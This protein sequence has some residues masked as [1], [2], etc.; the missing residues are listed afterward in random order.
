MQSFLAEK[1]CICRLDHWK[2]TYV[3]DVFEAIRE[4]LDTHCVVAKVK[5]FENAPQHVSLMLLLPAKPFTATFT[6]VN[7]L[8]AFEN[9]IF[10]LIICRPE[11]VQPRLV[12]K[13]VCM[14][15]AMIIAAQHHMYCKCD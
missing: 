7:V 3:F 13:V 12:P 10:L 1:A 9:C 5:G 6:H 15:Q 4:Q 2:A 8:H 11:A 14:T